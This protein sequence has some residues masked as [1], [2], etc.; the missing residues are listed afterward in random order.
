MNISVIPNINSGHRA[1]KTSFKGGY[2]Q[3]NG[4][5]K[6]MLKGGKAVSADEF[7]L[8]NPIMLELSGAGSKLVDLLPIK[9]YVLKQKLALIGDEAKE[10]E[11]LVANKSSDLR[12]FLNKFFVGEFRLTDNKNMYINNLTAGKMVTEINDIHLKPVYTLGK[13]A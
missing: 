2:A 8:Q 13:S 11:T 9:T 10:F 4:V 1:N 7:M 3:I 6:D 5:W 12:L